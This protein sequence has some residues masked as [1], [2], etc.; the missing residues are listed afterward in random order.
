MLR[1]DEMRGRIEVRVPDLAGN[2]GNASA[3]AQLVERGQ[4]PQFRI[5]GF[6]LPGGITGGAVQSASSIFIQDIEE[7]ILVVLVCRVASDPAGDR[8]LDEITPL[9][10]A[11]IAA[12]VGWGPE[13]APG[14]Y[15]L[16]RGELVG[17]QSGALIF[18]L[19]FTLSDQLRIVP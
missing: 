8:A 4:L 7:T 5:G 13:D 18:Q 19:D 2:L 1:L 11:V 6:I 16:T 10:R 3:F 15:A 17:S 12:V 14:V 9:I